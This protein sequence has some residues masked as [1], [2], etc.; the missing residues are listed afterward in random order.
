MDDHRDRLEVA[1]DV[2]GLK[3]AKGVHL[4][5]RVFFRVYLEA[6]A[7]LEIHDPD[8]AAAHDDR[9]G[10]SARTLF[11]GKVANRH[12]LLDH[13]GAALGVLADELGVVLDVLDHVG[14]DKHLPL[15]AVVLLAVPV[16]ADVVG[17][18]PACGKVAG[19]QFVG[20]GAF[21]GVDAAGVREARLKGDAS[22]ASHPAVGTAGAEFGVCAH[23][24]V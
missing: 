3:R 1:E 16:L 8:V 4:E 19:G 7:V 17:K 9:V 24:G 10:R 2:V 23:P 5:L 6:H 21:A 14:V 13:E 18:I 11:A 12:T 15:C 22:R 20:H